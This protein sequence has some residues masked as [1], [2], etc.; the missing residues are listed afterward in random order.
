MNRRTLSLIVLLVSL[1]YLG[2]AAIS[3]YQYFNV[4]Q[5]FAYYGIPE[6]EQVD[7]GRIGE[8]RRTF[9][10]GFVMFFVV[11]LPS[12]LVGI[13]LYLSREWARKAWLILAVVLAVFS[14]SRFVLAYPFREFWLLESVLEVILFGWLAIISWKTLY[15]RQ[16]VSAT[17]A[18]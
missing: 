17:A 12:L 7:R 9:L 8:L 10:G 11:G 13:G 6:V 18:S 15:G 14:L 5:V 2:L 16:A 1:I 4:G 3:I